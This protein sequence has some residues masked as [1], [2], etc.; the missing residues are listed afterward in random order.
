MQEILDKLEQVINLTP[1]GEARNLLTEIN[2]SLREAEYSHR[3]INAFVHHHSKGNW[4]VE[5]SEIDSSGRSCHRI[6]MGFRPT[7]DQIE[8]DGKLISQSYNLIQIAEMFHDHLESV[9]PDAMVLGMVKKVIS[10][11]GI[12]LE[13]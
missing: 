7:K 10:D 5:K 12:T 4:S 9:S 2:I 6:N 8:N 11:A 13:N 3:Q 1:T